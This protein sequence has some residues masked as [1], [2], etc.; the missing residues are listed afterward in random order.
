MVAENLIVSL[1]STEY[2]TLIALSQRFEVSLTWLGLRGLASV[3][4]LTQQ[5][6]TTGLRHDFLCLTPSPENT[7][8]AVNNEP[9]H[10]SPT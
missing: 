2:Q 1:G 10:L 3:L 7:V 8:E 6:N 9:C 5:K 4:C